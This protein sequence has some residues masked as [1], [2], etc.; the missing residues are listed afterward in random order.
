MKEITDKL[1]FV[2]IKIFFSVKDM[3]KRICEKIFA[4]VTYNKGLL[5]KI[6]SP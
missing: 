3:V 6:H 5:C 1:D 2:K 4:K